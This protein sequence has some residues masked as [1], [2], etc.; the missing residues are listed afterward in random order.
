MIELNW[1]T[2]SPITARRAEVI[3]FIRQLP[4]SIYSCLCFCFVEKNLPHHMRPSGSYYS[5]YRDCSWRGPSIANIMKLS[6][7]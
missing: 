3:F 1:F 5:H 2:I 4:C 6:F 7:C